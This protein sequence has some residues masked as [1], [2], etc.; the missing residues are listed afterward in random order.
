MLFSLFLILSPKSEAAIQSGR[1]GQAI[2]AGTLEKG[3]LQT[4]LGFDQAVL[5]NTSD[6][7]SITSISNVLRLGVNEIFE[8]GAAFSY[9]DLNIKGSNS[10]DSEGFNV[11]NVGFR[12][13]IVAK[14]QGLI[15]KVALQTRFKLKAVDRDFR[16]K[17]TSPVFTI[18]AFHGL[19]KKYSLLTNVGVSYDGND[20]KNYEFWVL[21]L[22]KE[23]SPKTS[24]FVEMYGDTANS[25]SSV[26]FDTGFDYLISDDMK[27]D[28]SGGLSENHSVE[29]FFLSVGLS[30]RFRLF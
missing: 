18:S 10:S 9:K 23:V 21:N 8:I 11:F 16:P 14:Q 15:P 7:Q 4:Q 20:G 19:S 22:S 26:Y 25:K 1:P 12:S 3:F 29:E 2:G 17:N 28:F 6:D 13:K 24:I 27:L 5:K 30:A